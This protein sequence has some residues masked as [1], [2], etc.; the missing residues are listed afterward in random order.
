MPKDADGR[1]RVFALSSDDVAAR[2]LRSIDDVAA[3]DLRSTMLRQG[4]FERSAKLG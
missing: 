1:M 3:R 2:D 4:S